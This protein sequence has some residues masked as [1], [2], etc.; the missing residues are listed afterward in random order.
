MQTLENRFKIAFKFYDEDSNKFVV[1]L[2]ELVYPYKFLD[3]RED[4]NK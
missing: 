4:F 1:L 2:Q 3:I